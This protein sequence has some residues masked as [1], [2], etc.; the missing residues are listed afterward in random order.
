MKFLG[1]GLFERQ[2]WLTD[3]QRVF[4][5]LW[6]ML[7]SVSVCA[8]VISWVLSS[9]TCVKSGG[10]FEIGLQNNQLFWGNIFFCNV[11]VSYKWFCVSVH[12]VCTFM[13]GRN[14]TFVSL[15]HIRKKRSVGWENPG[16]RWLKGEFGRVESTTSAG[17]SEAFPPAQ[18]ETLS[19]PAAM[20]FQAH[21]RSPCQWTMHGNDLFWVMSYFS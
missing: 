13:I 1:G 18:E 2:A 16:L 9:D 20:E 12:D 11:C 8:W 15:G 3:T 7:G 14:P 17:K 10:V 6:T 21:A 4:L 5:S 19:I